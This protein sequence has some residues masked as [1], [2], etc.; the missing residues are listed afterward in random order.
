MIRVTDLSERFGRQS[1]RAI[2]AEMVVVLAIIGTFDYLTGYE[3]RLLPLY[4]VP[5]F[6]AA[7]FLSRRT[8]VWF[9]LLAGIVSLAADWL[10]NDPD[11]LGWTRIWEITR[12]MSTGLVVAVVASMLRHKHDSAVA[13]IELLEHSQ[14]L[15][16]EI[17]GIS[18]AEQRRIGQDLHDG[19]CQYLAGLSCAATLLR[20]DLRKMKLKRETAAA[21]ELADLL[22]DAVVQ[23]RD[24]AR[25][26]VPA[27][28]SQVGLILGLEALAKS[29]GKLRGIE[30]SFEF[31]GIARKYNE[32]MARHLYRIAQESIN[33]AIRH[34]K[35][36]KIAIT[37]ETTDRSTT[38]QV[39]DDGSGLPTNRPQRG[40]MG[41]NIMQYRAREAGGELRIESPPTG[42]TLISCIT[43]MRDEISE[44]AA[45]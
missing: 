40:G 35:A 41:L 45:A 13:R 12:H 21:E 9:A 6:V 26:L 30:C 24:L 3:V 8:A 1:S 19:L 33:N 37:I 18:D 39:R 25:G 27:H 36:K 38:L 7:W 2:L 22:E 32:R 28:L 43:Q 5:I 23:T 10:T 20:D 4:S 42:G 29:V 15:E 16:R 44:S 31:R 34:G 14:R 11:L 17:V